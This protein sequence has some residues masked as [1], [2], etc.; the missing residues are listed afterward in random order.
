MIKII[1]NSPLKRTSKPD[2]NEKRII[3]EKFFL[4]IIR[5][6]KIEK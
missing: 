3:D 2:I 4:L 6:K 5:K 1:T